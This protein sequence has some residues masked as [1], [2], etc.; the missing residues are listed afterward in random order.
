MKRKFLLVIGIMALAVLGEACLFG[1]PT[2]ISI[3]SGAEA[4]VEQA[5]AD[6]AKRQGIDKEEIVVVEVDSVDWPDTSLGCPEPGMIYAQ[7]I[8]PGYKILLA[9]AQEIYEYHSDKC[10][11]VVYCGSRSL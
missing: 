8:T 5:K 6:L 7:V 4:A 2:N 3:P 10:D 1:A 11:Y 9:Y